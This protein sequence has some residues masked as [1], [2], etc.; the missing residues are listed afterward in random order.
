MPTLSCSTRRARAA[1]FPAA[2]AGDTIALSVDHRPQRWRL[3]GVI[4]ETLTPGAAYVIP[5]TL[6]S[7][8]R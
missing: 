4:D 7:R 6:R 8:N 1:A 5:A 2:R 3:V